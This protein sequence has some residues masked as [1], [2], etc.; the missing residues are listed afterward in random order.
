[1][2]GDMNL[3]QLECLETD[4]VI[5]T[6]AIAVAIDAFQKNNQTVHADDCWEIST[7]TKD[8]KGK[9]L[10]FFAD[11]YVSKLLEYKGCSRTVVSYVCKATGELKAAGELKHLA[12]KSGYA[13]MHTAL[14]IR[15]DNNTVVKYADG[16]LYIKKHKLAGFSGNRVSSMV[17]TLVALVEC[18]VLKHNS[19]TGTTARHVRDAM[20]HVLCRKESTFT[21]YK[22]EW[23]ITFNAELSA[24][25][26]PALQRSAV[27]TVD[28]TSYLWPKKFVAGTEKGK[29]IECGIKIYNTSAVQDDRKG[30]PYQQ[31]PG[32]I[33]KFEIT[34][35][36]QFFYRQNETLKRQGKKPDFAR[37]SDFKSQ[38]DIFVLLQ[39]HIVKQFRRFVLKPLNDDE[40]KAF[41]HATGTTEVEFMRKLKNPA[42]LQINMNSVAMD[43]QNRLTAVENK[44][45]KNTADIE[46]I[47]TKLAMYAFSQDMR[48]VRPDAAY[49][50]NTSYCH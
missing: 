34:F 17:D 20:R 11:D 33:F 31:L 8:S 32:D 5:E 15:P 41:Y 19:R 3:L 21:H 28:G 9:L 14:T 36:H 42:S 27:S 50:P 18:G 40:L 12:D 29:V 26:A 38:H 39:K 45:D 25:V 10:S 1:M 49:K 48:K 37:I 35:N 22:F 23:Q 24:I 4:C 30:K 47:K 46:N 13:P 2:G 43:I 6:A 16:Q 7:P 44:V